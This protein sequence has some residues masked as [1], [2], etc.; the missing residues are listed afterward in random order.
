MGDV[1]KI[2]KNWHIFS[3][4]SQYQ[5]CINVIDR[6][7]WL[8]AWLHFRFY[9]EQIQFNMGILD[10]FF[11]FT[12]KIMFSFLQCHILDNWIIH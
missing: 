3:I 9:E 7:V 5:E 2:Y 11:L 4:R 1:V 12:E 8:S 10:S 6:W